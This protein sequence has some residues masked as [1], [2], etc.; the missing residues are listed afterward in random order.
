M[1]EHMM[2]TVFV[3]GIILLNLLIVVL[4]IPVV[5]FFGAVTVVVCA[6]VITWGLVSYKERQARGRQ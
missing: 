6:N 1:K 4:Y 3:I 5:G 2:V